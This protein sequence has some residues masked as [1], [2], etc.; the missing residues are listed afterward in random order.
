LQDVHW[1]L[2]SF[3]Y[4]PTYTLG[5]LYAAQLVE[6]YEQTHDLAAELSAGDYGPLLRWLRRHVHEVGQRY[7]AEEIIRRVTGRGL[8]SGAFLRALERKYA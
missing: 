2:G 8:D 4:F 5:N 3:G 1:A 7:N 6:A